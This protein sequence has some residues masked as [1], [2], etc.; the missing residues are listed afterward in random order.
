MKKFIY[1]DHSDI[2]SK[3]VFECTAEDI[4]EADKKYQAATG[5][6]PEK[7]PYVGCEIKPVETA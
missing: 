2:P 6:N 7:Q 3:A 4:L 1:T 5:K